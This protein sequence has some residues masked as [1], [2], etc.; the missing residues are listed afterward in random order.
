MPHNIVFVIADQHRWDFLGR[1][2]GRT[3]TPELDRLAAGGA[4]FRRAYCT[5]PLCSPS[6][7]ASSEERRGGKECRSR[8]ATLR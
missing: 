7:A 2:D 1:A 4:G 3:L 6:R 5:A 8:W